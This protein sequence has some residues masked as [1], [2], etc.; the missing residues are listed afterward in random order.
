MEYI[1]IVFVDLE[2]GGLALEYP[3]IQIGAV[4]LPTGRVFERKLRFNKDD[5]HPAAMAKNNYDPEIWAKEA[6]D[7]LDAWM[8]FSRFLD[9]HK[10]EDDIVLGGHNI[11]DFDMDF[12]ND[13]FTKHSIKSNY[14][15]VPIDTMLMHY[16]QHPGE[17]KSLASCCERLEI[18]QGRAHDALDDAKA[19]MLVYR[20]L[21]T[22]YQ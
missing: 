7:P 2:T 15:R 16:Y 20:K 4:A 8:D 17:R 5:C 1:P 19:S 11:H 12:I 9:A 14:R 22:R 3:V 6:V 21:T 10:K 18:V 13:A